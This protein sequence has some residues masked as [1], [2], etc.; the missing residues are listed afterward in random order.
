MTGGTYRGYSESMGSTKKSFSDDAGE[1]ARAEAD[2]K[3]RLDEDRARMGEKKTRE[4]RDTSGIYDRNKVRL[5]ITRPAPGVEKILSF[6]EIR[7]MYGR[8]EIEFVPGAVNLILE[9]ENGVVVV[10]GGAFR[11]LTPEQSLMR[12]LE[13]AGYDCHPLDSYNRETLI[14]VNGRDRSIKYLKTVF[15]GTNETIY[16]RYA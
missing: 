8:P 6:S 10:S 13:R 15:D 5:S 9:D 2:R 1:R 12:H 3:R 7:S 4:T 14:A 11:Y 16:F